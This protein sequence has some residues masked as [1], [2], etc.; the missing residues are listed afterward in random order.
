MSNRV[1]A[2]LGA[3][4]M[5]VITNSSSRRNSESLPYVHKVAV[6]PKQN[7][8]KEIAGTVKETF[9]AD[10]PLRNFKDQSKSRKFV[11]GF[12]AIFP[13]FEWG[14][15]YSLSKFK[16]DLIA[17]L[18]I[19][20]LCIPQDIGYAKLA[21]LDPQYGLYSSFVPPLVYAFMGSSRDIAIG[22]VAVVSLLL[23]SLLQDEIDPIKNPVDYLR[24]AFTATFF[25]GITQVTLGFLRYMGQC[26]MKD[27]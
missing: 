22:P 7:L 20:S 26:P 19:A 27:Y 14:R 23:G 5:D 2:E 13:I 8:L 9:F 17:G 12:Q 25:A 3:N 21:N 6:P 10:D 1:S 15:N 18:T 16:G 4:E 24:L 11:L